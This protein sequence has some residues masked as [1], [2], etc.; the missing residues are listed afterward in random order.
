MGNGSSEITKAKQLHQNETK[1]MFDGFSFFLIHSISIP[2]RSNVYC[3]CTSSCHNR[4]FSSIVQSYP[5]KDELLTSFHT[6]SDYGLRSLLFGPF[7]IV[8]LKTGTTG[9]PKV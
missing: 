3:N 7:P 8:R 9:S 1:S 5:S 2:L 6:H 4:A